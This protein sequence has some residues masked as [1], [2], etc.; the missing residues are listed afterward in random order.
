MSLL[1]LLFPANL[2]PAPEGGI[3]AAYCVRLPFGASPATLTVSVVLF[4]VHDG[5]W[6]SVCRPTSSKCWPPLFFGA[7][8]MLYADRLACV[9]PH[10][11]RNELDTAVVYYLSWST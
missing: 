1:L 7:G 8:I 6:L 3:A 10:Q 4:G 5:L 9:M 11:K 2:Y